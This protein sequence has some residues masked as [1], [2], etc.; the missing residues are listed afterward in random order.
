MGLNSVIRSV[1][2]GNNDLEDG[3][4]SLSADSGDMTT[5]LGSPSA[6]CE[7]RGAKHRVN[8]VNH[9]LVSLSWDWRVNT[10][11]RRMQYAK[12]KRLRRRKRRTRHFG[13]LGGGIVNG[14]QRR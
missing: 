5:V 12:G 7:T 1:Q 10:I 6:R 11:F 13:E 8:M 4:D 3:L 14:H 9:W 2:G